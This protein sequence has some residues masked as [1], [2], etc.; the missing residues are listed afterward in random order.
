[1]Q[2]ALVHA[3]GLLVA[4]LLLGCGSS[5]P[6]VIHPKVAIADAATCP[7]RSP[8]LAVASVVDKRGYADPNNVGFTQTGMWNVRASLQTDR[9]AAEL[10]AELMQRA[11]ER[12]RL[13]AA[14]G[15][16]VL[17]KADLLSMQLTETTSFTSE[18]I[19]GAV[20]YEV[21][22]TDAK[23]KKVLARFTPE[24]SAE[25]SGI[26]TTNYAEPVLSKA[27]GS[28][29]SNFLAYLATIPAVSGTTEAVATASE[30]HAPSSQPVDITIRVLPDP[31]QEKRFGTT[32]SN[33]QVLAIEIAVRRKV[34]PPHALRFR[35]HHFRMVFQGEKERFPLDP[36]KVNERHRGTMTTMIYTGGVFVP[37]TMETAG[38]TKGL[39]QSVEDLTMPA[40]KSELRGVLFF[41]L[42]GLSQPVPEH[43]ELDYEDLSTS[44]TMRVVLG[45]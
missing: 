1:M 33:K 8:T 35:R 44:E 41:D 38:D 10:V 20:R 5:A 39:S 28:T 2:W 34:G 6:I 22:A 27:L 43:L 18:T 21:E 12:C 37:M 40:E 32:F 17:L 7:T 11:L 3:W 23:S 4:A 30:V 45:R 29:A 9:T 31:E 26:D 14:S 15:A 16:Q 42:E 19:K 36:L 25:A 13:A 24:G